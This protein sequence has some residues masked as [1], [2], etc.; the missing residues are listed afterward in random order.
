MAIVAA[1]I[2]AVVAVLS[3]APPASA[4]PRCPPRRRPRS[5]S[6]SG[7]P[8]P[9]RRRARSPRSRR[10]A[11][12]GSPCSDRRRP[13]SASSVWAFRPTASTAPRR[14]RSP[15]TRPSAEP[16][17]VPRCLLPG[18]RSGLVGRGRQ[19]THLQHPRAFGHQPVLDHREPLRFRSVYDYAVNIAVKRSGSP[20]RCRNLPA[21]DR[22]QPHLGLW[23][24]VARKII[25]SDVAGSGRRPRITIG[26]GTPS[27]VSAKA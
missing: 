1:N 24:S 5:G 9:T 16:N 18:H 13:R 4:A 27:L 15:S 11:S 20:A 22:R 26:V 21:R 2:G 25:P 8:S 14:A 17:R 12:S 6:S 23:P 3:S 10:S 7:F 19:L